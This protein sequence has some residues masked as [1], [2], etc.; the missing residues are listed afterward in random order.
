[1]HLLLIYADTWEKD[2]EGT[3]T[4]TVHDDLRVVTFLLC[5]INNIGGDGGRWYMSSVIWLNITIKTFLF[6]GTSRCIL[7]QSILGSEKERLDRS[8]ERCNCQSIARYLLDCDQAQR[9]EDV[10]TRTRRSILKALS[11]QLQNVIRPGDCP[12]ALSMY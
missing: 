1:L 4:E 11:G 9:I 7:I 3:S 6:P 8:L 5:V 12:L 2:I 10:S